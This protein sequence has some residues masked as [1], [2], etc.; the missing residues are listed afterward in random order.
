[1]NPTTPMQA[2]PW[3][4]EAMVWFV[5]A[6][7]L[8]SVFTGFTMLY[9]AESGKDGMVVDDYYRKG[10]EINMLPGPR[11]CRRTLRAARRAAARWRRAARHVRCRGRE[12]GVAGAAESALAACD[13]RRF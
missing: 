6:I 4:R 8:T 10:K 12:R 3:Y 1:M 9:L 13:P 2:C 7:P 11:P 5:I